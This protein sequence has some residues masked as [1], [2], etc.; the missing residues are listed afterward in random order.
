MTIRVLHVIA[1]M[2]ASGTERQMVG[3]VRAAQ[4]HDLWTPVVGVLYSGFAL[5]TQLRDAGIEVI[6]FGDDP[7]WHPAR[8]RALR[9]L[10]LTEDVDVVHTSLWGGSVVGRTVAATVRPMPAMVMSERRVEDFRTLPKR[11]LD[12]ALSSVTNA[13]IGNSTSVTDFIVRA[14]GVSPARVTE[15]SNGIDLDVFA[16][17]TVKTDVSAAKSTPPGRDRPLR[18]GAIGRLV[19]QKGFDLLIKALPLIAAERPVEL[20]IV[21]EG[22]LAA[23][24][25]RAAGDLPVTFE[26][27]LAEPAD[28][29]AFLHSLDVFVMPSRYE[30]LPNALLEAQACRIPSVATDAPGIAEASGPGVVLV[31]P[32]SPAALAKG[33]LEQADV[34]QA[35]AHEGLRDF[36]AVA[37]DHLDVFTRARRSQDLLA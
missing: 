24:L 34:G 27:F 7:A 21:G 10:I 28:V 30:G 22:P 17:P 29:A 15:I 13:Y 20:R 6:E 33:I 31:A 37:A 26:G 3:M 19:H 8:F 1:R 23:D 2:P 18:L 14:H 16:A 35:E 36:H 11:A 9:R 5:S 25:T 32:E 12:R 4:R